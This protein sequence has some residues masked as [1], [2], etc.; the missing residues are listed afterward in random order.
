MTVYEV[1]ELG[2]QKGV[3]SGGIPESTSG[4]ELNPRPKI[5][6]VCDDNNTAK[7]MTAIANA[8]E[9]GNIEDG[10]FSSIVLRIQ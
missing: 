8:A 1:K 7:I 2:T 4:F 3:T 5:K 6:I 10:R 9:T